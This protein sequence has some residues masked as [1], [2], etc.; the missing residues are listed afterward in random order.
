MEKVRVH[1]VAVELTARCNQKC[2]YC[3]NSWRDDGGAEMGELSTE[4]L[5]GL[6]HKLFQEAEVEHITLTGGEP[7]LRQDIFELI[8]LINQQDATVSIISNGGLITR[9]KA[10]RL[11][12]S[13]V[14][15]VQLS[16]AGADAETHD[17]ICGKQSFQ[18]CVEATRYLVE[19]GIT[20]CGS[21]ICSKKSWRQTEQVLR[22]MHSLGFTR[23]AFNRFN[24]SGYGIGATE[25]LLPTRTEVVS[26]LEVAQQIAVELGLDITCTMPIPPC[27]FDEE[28][29][30]NIEFGSC[31]AGTLDGE[32][33][34][35]PDGSFKLCTLQKNAV[36]NFNKVSLVD[37]INSGE[38]EAFR[39]KI[40]SFCEGCPHAET[41]LGG[42]GASSEWLFG[43]AGELDPFVAQHVMPKLWQALKGRS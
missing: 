27:I 26:A 2:S 16:F 31:S 28:S 9:E 10:Q 11:A 25:T 13:Q 38:F 32:L 36:G 18:R 8:E 6:L 34:L 23:V 1:S 35:G 15:Q 5:Q 7:F 42:C 30:P 20:V 41:C 4:K 17:P 39:Q 22:L 29:Y 3:Y 12:E 33:A 37:M 24:P 43:D 14:S 21:F 40:P 19:A